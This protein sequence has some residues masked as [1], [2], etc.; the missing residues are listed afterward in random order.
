MGFGT[1]EFILVFKLQGG[2]T[3][4]LAQQLDALPWRVNCR[5]CSD[6]GGPVDNDVCQDC[7]SSLSAG[8][9]TTGAITLGIG[10][11]LA[12]LGGGLTSFSHD[13]AGPGQSYTVFYGLVLLGAIVGLKGLY[14]LIAG[15][16]A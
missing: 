3:E 13:S 1:D 11:V 2:D 9:R 15:R 5:K 12:A 6:C 7:V 10:L 16:R 8:Y 14:M 4:G